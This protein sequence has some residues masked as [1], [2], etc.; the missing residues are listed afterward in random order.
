MRVAASRPDRD[1]PPDRTAPLGYRR[2]RRS[3]RNVVPGIEPDRQHAIS[4]RKIQ[5]TTG[6][7]MPPLG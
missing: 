7:A 4:R 1:K 2:L 3:G 6:T 5:R